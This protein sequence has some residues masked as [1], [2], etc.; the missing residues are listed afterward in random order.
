MSWNL[1]I[2]LLASLGIYFLNTL[3]W[4]IQDNYLVRSHV[5]L[6]VWFYWVSP[7]TGTRLAQIS[8]KGFQDKTLGKTKNNWDW[9]R[10]EKYLTQVPAPVLLKTL[11]PSLL[12]KPWTMAKSKIFFSFIAHRAWSYTDALMGGN[13]QFYELSMA[14]DKISEGGPQGGGWGLQ[15]DG[16]IY[17]NP[18]PRPLYCKV[19]F[20][21]LKNVLFLKS[22]HYINVLV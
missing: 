5:I 12:S 10:S 21:Y 16:Q 18:L 14:K 9:A 4:I 6:F 17:Q 20:I 19:I 8:L 13:K 7:A 3:S 1:A 15:I 11:Q 22:R 2:F